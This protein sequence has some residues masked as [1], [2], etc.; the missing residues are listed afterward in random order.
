M[1]I[2]I[3]IFAILLVLDSLITYF[4]YLGINQVVIKFF[5]KINIKLIAL[6]EGVFGLVILHLQFL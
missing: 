4:F 2:G 3:T 1:H 5:P 6:V